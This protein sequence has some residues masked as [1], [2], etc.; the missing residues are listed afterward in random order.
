MVVGSHFSGI[1][2]TIF[3]VLAT[4]TFTG[5][6]MVI[7]GL[8][9]L[10]SHRRRSNVLYKFPLVEIFQEWLFGKED[11]GQNGIQLRLSFQNTHDLPLGYKMELVRVSLRDQDSWQESFR[12]TAESDE[13]IVAPGI[14]ETF[15][16]P[17]IGPFP[18]DEAPQHVSVE[19]VI[20]YGPVSH[21]RTLFRWRE[22]RKL[23]ATL[24]F[25][26]MVRP[27]ASIPFTRSGNP[28]TERLGKRAS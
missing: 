17:P 14:R 21:D 12:Q 20:R 22:T 3:G 15:T 6:L 11:A 9:S 4:A 7:G 16:L 23:V 13:E 28:V 19:Y 25:P 18:R 27:A 8:D 24:E 10:V 2:W 26:I 5:G 1:D